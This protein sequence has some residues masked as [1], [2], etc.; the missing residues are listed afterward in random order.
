MKKRNNTE[1]NNRISA[2]MF[3]IVRST[4]GTRTLC[5]RQVAASARRRV[6]SADHA[7]RRHGA[8]SLRSPLLSSAPITIR[9]GKK[10]A[11]RFT[12]KR[13]RTTSGSPSGLVV[14]GPGRVGWVWCC[15]AARKMGHRLRGKLWVLPILDVY[16]NGNY[17][18]TKRKREQRV[19]VVIFS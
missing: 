3:A 17:L 14:F 7:A 4:D 1:C 8:S 12:L 19:L 11:D 10:A 16:S 5:P 2:T 13:F 6:L 15:Y 18:D 9:P